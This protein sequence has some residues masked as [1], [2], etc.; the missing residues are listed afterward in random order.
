M[1]PPSIGQASNAALQDR[2]GEWFGGGFGRF[3]FEKAGHLLVFLMVFGGFL[4]FCPN[5]VLEGLI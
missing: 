5:D 1:V 2:W 3:G 4:G